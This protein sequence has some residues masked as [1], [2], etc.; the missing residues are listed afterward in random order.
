MS[1]EE[2]SIGEWLA[3]LA[4]RRKREAMRSGSVASHPVA[5]H[6]VANSC[7]SGRVW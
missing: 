3:E 6:S 4:S 7:T 5:S 1:I 2:M